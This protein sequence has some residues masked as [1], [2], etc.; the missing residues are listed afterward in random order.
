ML[1]SGDG[2]ERPN[3]IGNGAVP[4]L[5]DPKL[6]DD[7][8]HPVLVGGHHRTGPQGGH[9]PAH[10]LAGR[11]VVGGGSGDDEPLT[12]GR[13]KGRPHEIGLTTRGG[14]VVGPK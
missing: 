6:G 13:L 5:S 9:D 11:S 4:Q 1:G 8:V 12:T 3:P 2:D 7:L 10:H 14:D